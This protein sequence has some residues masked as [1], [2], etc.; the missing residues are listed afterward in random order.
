MP[1][2]AY[3]SRILDWYSTPND[4]PESS[5]CPAAR[6]PRLHPI[7]TLG[8]GILEGVSSNP[9]DLMK[10]ECCSFASYCRP[11][12]P[13]L[14]KV[15]SSCLVMAMQ[16]EQLSLVSLS[17]LRLHSGVSWG[18]ITP[19]LPVCICIISLTSKM[20]PLL[21]AFDLRQAQGRFRGIC[22]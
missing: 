8:S 7:F 13:F 6:E 12:S 20:R 4:R 9:Q 2:D 16:A 11:C 19:Q 21:F 3:L 17:T 5:S 15:D 18:D 22:L 1:P 10:L 14:Q